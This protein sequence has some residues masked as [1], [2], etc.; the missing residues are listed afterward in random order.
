MLNT[1]YLTWKRAFKI[2]SFSNRNYFKVFCINTMWLRILHEI[3]ALV[4]YFF[5]I[6]NHFKHSIGS[7][8]RCFKIAKP[9]L[10][11]N[12]FAIESLPYRVVI[13]TLCIP[14]TS[15]AIKTHQELPLH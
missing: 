10:S 9:K 11:R 6:S 8:F 1:Q 12:F 3:N 2:Y 15:L 4:F 5:K 7:L 13:K 14:L